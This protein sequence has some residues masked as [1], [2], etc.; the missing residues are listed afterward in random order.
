MVGLS[1]DQSLQQKLQAR[2]LCKQEK[3][4]SDKVDSYHNLLLTSQ[5]ATVIEPTHG[6]RSLG[7]H[8]IW[9]Y[10]DL[11]YFMVLREVQGMYRQTALGLSW[12]F[13]RPVINVAMLSLTF[14]VLVKVPS[15]GVPYPLFSLAAILPWSY[16]SSSVNRSAGSLVQNM[17]MISKVY[18]PRVILPLG[19]VISGLVDMG[20]S[21]IVLLVM[22]IIYRVPLRAELLWLPVFVVVTLALSLAIGLWLATLSVKY[23]DVAFAITFLLQAYMYASPVIYPVSLVPEPFV[24]LYKLNPMVGVIEGFRW[25]LLGSGSSP[26]ITFLLSIGIVLILLIQGAFIFRRTERTIVDLL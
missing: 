26:D 19:A 10:R 25:A 14:G 7:L 3:W 11:L 13:L 9:E 1:L 22:L 18:F 8:E 23:R 2:L 17:S 20:A 12:L 6:W 24:F 16:F 5:A 15:N 21:F 4:M